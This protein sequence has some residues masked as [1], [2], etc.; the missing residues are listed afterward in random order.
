MK[1]AVRRILLLGALLSPTA[2]YALGLGDIRLNSALN[3]P[4]DAEIQL[5]RAQRDELLAVVQL[6]RALGGGWTQ[7]AS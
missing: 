2:L 4:F 1:I 6:Y 5:T 7:P 3:Q